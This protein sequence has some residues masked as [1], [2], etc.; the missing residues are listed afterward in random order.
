MEGAVAGLVLLAV[1]VLFAIVVVAKSVALIPQAEAAVIERLGRYSKTVSGQLTLL[2]PFVDKIRARVDLRERV[3]SFPPQP[4]ITE[5]NLTVNIDTV[6]YFQVTNPQAAVYQISNYIVGVEQ[7]TT[8]T[9]RNVVGGMTLE[10]TLTSRDSING[11]LRGVLDEATGRWGLR[12]ARVELRSIDPPPSIQESMEKQ[13]RADR[14]K[15]AMILMAEGSRE[16]AI[17]AAEGQKQAQILSAEGA[18]QAAILAAE[19]DRQSRMLRAQGERAAAYLQAQ[20]QAKAIE[21]TFA[22]IKNGRPT[23]E[24]LAYQYLQTLPQMAKGEAN[25]VWLVPSDFGAALQGFTKLLGAPGEDGVFRYTPSPVDDRP[26]K[27]DEDDAAEVADWFDTQTDP[28]IARAVAKAEAEARSS[29]PPLGSN[30]PPA[31]LPPTPPAAAVDGPT[32]QFPGQFPGG[33]HR[34]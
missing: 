28:E 26:A 16:S 32:Q 2:L 6:V 7:L 5:D 4:V 14:E 22:A 34:A 12:V 11:Q 15:R 31:S 9:L 8:T 20:G 1:L 3:V 21:K 25:K 33:S 18:K 27:S 29:T 23:P 19:A 30:P 13:M 24:M 10:Q 17:K